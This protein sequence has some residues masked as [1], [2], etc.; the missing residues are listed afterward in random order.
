[1]GNTQKTSQI[2]GPFPS[3][4]Q[5]IDLNNPI[6]PNNKKLTEK[7]GSRMIMRRSITFTNN[8]KGEELK[9][10]NLRRNLNN[11]FDYHCSQDSPIDDIKLIVSF[12][13]K[14]R[15]K[16]LRS[17]TISNFLTKGFKALYEHYSMLK[18]ISTLKIIC[19]S[20]SDIS[21]NDIKHL[22]LLLKR[23]P[24]LTNLYL[25]FPNFPIVSYEKQKFFNRIRFIENLS[26]LS[27]VFIDYENIQSVELENLFKSLRILNSFSN[28]SLIL[29]CCDLT[30]DVINIISDGLKHLKILRGLGLEFQLSRV[31]CNGEIIKFMDSLGQLKDLS[32]LSLYLLDF[33]GITKDLMEHFLFV[34]RTMSKLTS[35]KL[36]LPYGFASNLT[37][38]ENFYSLKTLDLE[39][40]I[41]L[42]NKDLQRVSTYL[43]QLPLLKK[44]SLT[45]VQCEKINSQGIEAMCKE[46]QCISLSSFSLIFVYCKF[47]N[48]KTF[49]KLMNLIENFKDLKSLYL[50]FTDHDICDKNMKK[51]ASALKQL[52]KLSNLALRFGSN[53]KITDEGV[54]NLYE[55][56]RGLSFLRSIELDFCH[57]TQLSQKSFLFLV[58]VLNQANY[59]NRAVLLFLDSSLKKAENIK[60]V[61]EEFFRTLKWKRIYFH[62]LFCEG[63]DYQ[64]VRFNPGI[65]SEKLV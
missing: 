28:L 17:I 59:L 23:L 34:I 54:M 42:S 15:S 43:A 4:D 51:L 57:C 30:M 9:Q 18:S 20:F 32:S 31:H 19:T 2:K 64:V 38:F 13:T 53:N 50:L 22:G 49:E 21:E 48:S 35:L 14:R 3:F 56:L 7:M 1:M 27:L 24:S 62:F 55:T 6:K 10:V 37:L 36:V 60:I 65:L 63:T 11:R 12:L 40:S 26:T 16:Y 41:S 47:I 58:E 25:E 46:M 61:K 52:A 33:Q 29:S 5:S 8:S 45:F 44:L 39:F